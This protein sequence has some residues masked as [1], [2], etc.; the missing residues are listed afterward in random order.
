MHQSKI[1]LAAAA[2]V[3]K[4]DFGIDVASHTGLILMLL[5]TDF[6]GQIDCSL[7][8]V[9]RSPQNT[10]VALRQI[11]VVASSTQPTS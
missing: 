6:V 7:G 5:I 11:R 9:N 1:Q 8:G 3:F 2:D 4:E 10:P